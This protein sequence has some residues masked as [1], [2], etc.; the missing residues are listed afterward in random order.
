V[1]THET[2]NYAVSAAMLCPNILLT[3]KTCPTAATSD[4]L[5]W[6]CS[7]PWPKKPVIKADL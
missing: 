5:T 7:S 4:Y 3:L 2:P 6:K 1:I